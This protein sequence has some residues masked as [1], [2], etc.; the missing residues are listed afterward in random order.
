MGVTLGNGKGTN[1]VYVDMVKTAFRNGNGKGKGRKHG[2]GFLAKKT[3]ARPL[4]D[5]E[6][7]VG[8]V[9]TGRI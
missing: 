7:H 3:L 5:T 2:D 1:N 6:G 4:T 9:K 8:S